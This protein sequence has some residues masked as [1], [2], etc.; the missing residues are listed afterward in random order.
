MRNMVRA[1]WGTSDQG[2]A[3]SG[4]FYGVTCGVPSEGGGW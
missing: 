2:R 3:D 4:A 1:Y